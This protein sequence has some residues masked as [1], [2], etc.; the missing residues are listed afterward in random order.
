[1]W[2]TAFITP[3]LGLLSQE[4]RSSQ[5]RKV[6][7]RVIR[8]RI[9]APV[10][11]LLEDPVIRHSTATAIVHAAYGIKTLNLAGAIMLWLLNQTIFKQKITVIDTSF[12]APLADEL[13]TEVEVIEDDAALTFRIKKGR[14][15][16]KKL[17]RDM[18]A[19]L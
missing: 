9:L 15:A 5:D 17:I 14:R 12:L 7:R 16:I 19:I 1:M 18:L 11:H 8:Q 13:K 2:W 3:V 4:F 6:L 10:L